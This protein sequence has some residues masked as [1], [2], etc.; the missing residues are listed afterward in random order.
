[1]GLK[2]AT[3]SFKKGDMGARE[4][5][6]SVLTPAFG[7]KLPEMM[8]QILKALPADRA[9]ALK[10]ASKVRYRIRP[11]VFFRACATLGRARYSKTASYPAANDL[12]GLMS[13]VSRARGVALP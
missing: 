1:M 12:L 8:P 7:D 11:T 4:Y 2:E 5:H 9:A 3:T 6:E 10:A 13:R